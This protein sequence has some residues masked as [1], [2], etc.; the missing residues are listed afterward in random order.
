M[1]APW[2]TCG[3]FHCQPLSSH[4]T[5]SDLH[6]ENGMKSFRFPTAVRECMN[7]SYLSL[8]AVQRPYLKGKGT[9]YFPDT[10][11]PLRAKPKSHIFV[12][13][14]QGSAQAASVSAQCCIFLCFNTL[15]RQG[16]RDRGSRGCLLTLWSSQQTESCWCMAFGWKFWLKHRSDH[17]WIYT[18]NIQQASYLPF[19]GT[20][21]MQPQMH[22]QL[23]RQMSKQLFGSPVCNSHCKH[24]GAE[25]TPPWASRVHHVCCNQA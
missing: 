10:L 20:P 21:L 23:L 19:S 8:R 18:R 14:E 12:F 17:G 9:Q 25:S 6:L 11:Y 5:T 1:P 7:P 16:G 13:R 22:C 15:A 2:L 24:S 4:L 3:L